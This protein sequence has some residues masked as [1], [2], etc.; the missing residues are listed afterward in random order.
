M[1]QPVPSPRQEPH[2]PQPGDLPPSVLTLLFGADPPSQLPVLGPG[3][4]FPALARHAGRR[5][6]RVLRHR[7]T[8]SGPLWRRRSPLLLGT[9]RERLRT[10]L[11]AGVLLLR[12]HSV[13]EQWRNL[14][15]EAQFEPARGSE[16]AV[17]ID[18]S[19]RLIGRFQGRGAVLRVGQPGRPNDPTPA[20]EALAGLPGVR[21][22]PDLFALGRVETAGEWVFSVEE[23]LPGRQAT[24]LNAA[25]LAELTRWL[26]DFGALPVAGDAD[27]DLANLLVACRDLLVAAAPT[28]ETEVDRLLATLRGS[29]AVVPARMHGDLW[30][31]NL[32]TE[33]TALTGV[34]D[35]DGYREVGPGGVDLVHAVATDLRLRRRTSLGVIAADRP[36]RDGELAASL[37]HLFTDFVTRPLTTSDL[38]AVG[39]AWWLT[40]TAT[41]L[42]RLP[43][44]AQDRDWL[45][46]N[47]IRPAQTLSA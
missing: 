22:V 46:A 45:Q 7:L 39:L 2:D 21:A 14:L 13:S 47:V 8:G 6:L 35:W 44:R 25:L 43:A 30:A 42:A 27:A 18:G 33:G 3:A 15:S 4:G 9:G 5:E 10:T 16:P 41:S 28:I 20:A 12:P 31:R 37:R 40:M 1:T 32:L 38:D 29:A 26:T 36:W 34:V 24:S 19:L 23:R 11:G 17:G